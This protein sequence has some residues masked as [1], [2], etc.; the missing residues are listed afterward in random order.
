MSLD[1]VIEEMYL[2]EK[3]MEQSSSRRIT[4]SRKK[5]KKCVAVLCGSSFKHKGVQLLLDPIIL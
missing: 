2:K 1:S 5:E 4:I 3:A